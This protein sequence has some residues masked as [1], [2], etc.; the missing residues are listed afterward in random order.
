MPTTEKSEAGSLESLDSANGMSHS[1]LHQIDQKPFSI[2]QDEVRV[3]PDAGVESEIVE[4]SNLSRIQYHRL[5]ILRTD[6]ERASS[7]P[8]KLVRLLSRC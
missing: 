6:R 7:V 8:M 3:V 5:E 4:S 2:K 1:L